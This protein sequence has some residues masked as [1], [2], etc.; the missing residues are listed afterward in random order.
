[1]CPFVV[2]GNAS[3]SWD[4]SWGCAQSFSLV[5]VSERQINSLDIWLL[6]I[7]V[8]GS[9]NV[10]DKV[11]YIFKNK[12]KICQIWNTLQME[13]KVSPLKCIPLWLLS[14]FTWMRSAF[15]QFAI[16]S[17][18]ILFL[19]T[20]KG[21]VYMKWD[22]L[23]ELMPYSPFLQLTKQT[24]PERVSFWMSYFTAYCIVTLCQRV[25]FCVTLRK[26]H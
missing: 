3:S 1:M 10:F 25:I 11:F 16:L 7:H 17:K 24:A 19:N 26:L 21:K 13:L 18:H 12:N 9:K 2:T 23:H 4:S 5:A 14:K 20:F 6:T 22:F 8:T 15:T